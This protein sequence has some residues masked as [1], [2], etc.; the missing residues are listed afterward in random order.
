MNQLITK[1]IRL[2]LFGLCLSVFSNAAQAQWGAAAIN[3]DAGNLIGYEVTFDGDPSH[4]E[5]DDYHYFWKV[6]D[7]YFYHG[8]RFTDT[9]PAPVG[10]LE[11][12][13]SKMYSEAEDPPKREFPPSIFSLGAVATQYEPMQYELTRDPRPGY[14]GYNFIKGGFSDRRVVRLSVEGEVSWKMDSPC[15]EYLDKE[16]LKACD[17]VTPASASWSPDLWFFVSDDFNPGPVYRFD[18]L[19][20][21]CTSEEAGP[22]REVRFTMTIYDVDSNSISL[23]NDWQS[24]KSINKGDVSKLR[25][26]DQ[27]PL[28]TTVK[29]SWDPNDKSVSQKIAQVGDT[30]I[31]L[32]QFENTGTASESG[33]VIYDLVPDEVELIWEDWRSSH[34]Y[35]LL[36]DETTNPDLIHLKIVKEDGSSEIIHPG[37][38]GFIVYKAKIRTGT[39][40]QTIIEN[41]ARIEFEDAGQ[42][43][44]TEPTFTVVW[45]RKTGGGG[46]DCCEVTCCPDKLLYVL[47]ILSGITLLFVLILVMRRR[48]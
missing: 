31:Y 12:T 33:V 32:I 38:Q 18:Y 13:T 40:P 11:L 27:I 24:S 7:C 1:T 4:E 10:K 17:W 29:E 46:G 9:L 34:F 42:I 26:L 48:S 25:Q 30:L 41:R 20:P 28:E 23:W 47:L 43:L 22:G 5:L 8:R 35:E 37:E 2:A 19:V 39:P 21:F 15:E 14:S 6:G 45:D 36:S 44:I 16:I 3:D